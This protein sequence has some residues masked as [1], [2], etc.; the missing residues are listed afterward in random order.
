MPWM[1]TSAI[2][3]QQLNPLLTVPMYYS[4]TLSEKIANVKVVVEEVGS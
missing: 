4:T 1:P 3:Q 2:S